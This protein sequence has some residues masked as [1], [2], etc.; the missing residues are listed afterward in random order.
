MQC[1]CFSEGLSMGSLTVVKATSGERGL[2]HNY[3][4]FNNLIPTPAS[5]CQSLSKLSDAT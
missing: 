4:I 2:K 5:L 1:A 3:H